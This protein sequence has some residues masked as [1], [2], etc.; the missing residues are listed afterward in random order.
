MY[1]YNMKNKSDKF[2]ELAN[3]RVNKT[4]KDIQLVGNLA[5]KQNY[6]YN[7]QQVKQIL[8]ALQHELDNVKNCFSTVNITNKKTFVLG[9]AEK[10]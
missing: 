3:K 5:N 7:E 2:I 10:E 8:K 6:E 4:L 1:I 9:E